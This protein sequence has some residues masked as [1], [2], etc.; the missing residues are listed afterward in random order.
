MDAMVTCNQCYE[1]GKPQ[2]VPA[3]T[4]D[5]RSVIAIRCIHCSAYVKR[6]GSRM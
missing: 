4:F 2:P 6:D 1:E 3:L 5:E